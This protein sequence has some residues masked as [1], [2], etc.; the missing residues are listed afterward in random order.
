MLVHK[1]K[2]MKKLTEDKVQHIFRKS[3][4]HDIE[5]FTETFNRYSESFGFETDFHVNAFLAQLEEEQGIDL[6][7]KREN[8]NYSCKA[9][10]AL[11]GY[12]KKHPKEATEDG[13]CNGHKANQKNIANKAYGGRIGNKN[14]NDGWTFRGAGYIQLTG[15]DNY[16][17]ISNTL[18]L[19]LNH[20]ITPED[21]AIDMETVEGSLLSA[22]GFFLTHKL[23]KAKTIDEMTALVNKHTKSYKQRKKHYKYIASL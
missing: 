19:V 9:L 12:Y 3:D 7:P 6:K 8:L 13:R 10:K 2:K 4:P 20:P 1:N 11:F 5:T 22:M 18:T 23:Y 15:R 17:Q 16:E 14:P 21:L